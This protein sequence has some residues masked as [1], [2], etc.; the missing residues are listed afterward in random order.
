MKPPQ[1]INEPKRYSQYANW[2]IRGK[3]TSGAPIWRGMKKF[4]NPENSGVA[5]IN[6][7]IV[8]CI[9]KSWLKVSWCMNCMPG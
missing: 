6:S 9:V 4:A 3:A 7:M 2:L 1:A 8:P 5:N